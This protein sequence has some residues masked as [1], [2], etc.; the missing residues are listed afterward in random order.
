MNKNERKSFDIDRRWAAK[1]IGNLYT[2][3]AKVKIDDAYL[4]ERAAQA[5]RDFSGI[6]E[7]AGDEAYSTFLAI[8]ANRLAWK[9]QVEKSKPKTRSVKKA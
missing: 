1:R 9:A 3:M 7:R 2:M 6:P 5:L 8:M 4:F